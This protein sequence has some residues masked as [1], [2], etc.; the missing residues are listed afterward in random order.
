MANKFQHGSIKVN[1]THHNL[2]QL[3]KVFSSLHTFPFCLNAVAGVV[4][5]AVVVV[6]VVVV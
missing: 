2:A 5:I 6:V 4:V 3:L 1:R